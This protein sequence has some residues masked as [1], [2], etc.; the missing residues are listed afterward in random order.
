V[1]GYVVASETKMPVFRLQ[2]TDPSVTEY[3]QRT[4]QHVGDSGFNLYFP[5]EVVLKAGDR[6]KISLKV[7]GVMSDDQ[8][9]PQSYFVIPR[10]SLANTPLL[11]AN[12]IG[13]IDA[14]YRGELIVAVYA[15]ADY[16][17]AKGQ[18]LF[19]VIH[20]SL[21]PFSGTIVPLLAPLDT[22]S[23]GSGG[24]GSTDRVAS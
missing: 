3:Y 16:T 11:M 21:Q 6:R 24:F 20:P 18:S 5:E 17:I 2:P 1:S 15:T 22:T 4:N 12:S 8:F 10:S 19:Q 9:N 13:L 14:G 7:V 23:R